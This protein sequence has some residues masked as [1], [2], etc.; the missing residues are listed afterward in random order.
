MLDWNVRSGLSHREFLPLRAFDRNRSFSVNH[1]WSRKNIVVQKT[2]DLTSF[3][4]NQNS[5]TGLSVIVKNF[6]VR[7]REAGG[8]RA[9]PQKFHPRSSGECHTSQ[10]SVWCSSS[11]TSSSLSS[12]STRCFGFCCRRRCCCC[13]CL[14]KR[15][16]ERLAK[17]KKKMKNWTAT[18]SFSVFFSLAQNE[19]CFCVTRI[20]PKVLKGKVLLRLLKNSVSLFSTSFLP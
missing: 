5:R 14:Q 13:C 8:R 6:W 2:F 15:K 1:W 16:K 11:S 3:R 10:I 17:K 19:N 20:K 18:P 4:S 7:V 12:P 9:R